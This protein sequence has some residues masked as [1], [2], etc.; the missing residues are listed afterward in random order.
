MG[1]PNSVSEQA[2]PVVEPMACNYQADITYPGQ[3]SL[4]AEIRQ[5]TALYAVLSR[6]VLLL[7]IAPQ[8]H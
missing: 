5:S 3:K 2:V 6:K 4:I 8:N 7:A 1:N